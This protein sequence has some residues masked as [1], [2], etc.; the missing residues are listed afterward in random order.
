MACGDEK[1]TFAAPGYVGTAGPP[2]GHMYLHTSSDLSL[3]RGCYC[4]LGRRLQ[5]FREKTCN[6][7]YSS[8]V[9]EFLVHFK[10][11]LKISDSLRLYFN[12]FATCYMSF[13]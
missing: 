12:D 1:Q 10:A 9:R 8:F 2:A 3:T 6:Y 11:S 13:V 4:L 7:A 5:E